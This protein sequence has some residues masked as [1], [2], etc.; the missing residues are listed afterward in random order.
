LVRRDGFNR[1]CRCVQRR[2]SRYDLPGKTSL[3]A[4]TNAYR[5]EADASCAQTTQKFCDL[6]EV[7]GFGAVAHR[8]EHCAEA[9]FL[10]RLS[11]KKILSRHTA[12]TR[13]I[14]VIVLAA[15]SWTALASGSENVGDV[16]GGHEQK[17]SEWGDA[18]DHHDVRARAA[19]GL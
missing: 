10:A 12:K 2:V 18:L 15:I 16:S 5:Q 4:V 9:D 17:Q 14:V 13:A 11:P 19:D 3:G 8:L 6:L 1:N 7:D